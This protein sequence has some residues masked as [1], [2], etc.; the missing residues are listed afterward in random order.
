MENVRNL[1]KS[2]HTVTVFVNMARVLQKSE[3]LSNEEAVTKAVEVLGYSEFP[4][5]YGLAAAAV[6]QLNAPVRVKSAK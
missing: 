4:D 1:P 5:G 2:L 6:R 3:T